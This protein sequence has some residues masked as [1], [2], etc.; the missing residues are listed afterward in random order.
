[1]LWW[2]MCSAGT[3]EQRFQFLLPDPSYD[4]AGIHFTYTSAVNTL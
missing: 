2:F 1:M 4:I 3:L